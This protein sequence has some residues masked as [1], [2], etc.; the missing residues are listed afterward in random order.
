MRHVTPVFSFLILTL[1]SSVAF[2][3]SEKEVDAALDEAVKTSR[4]EKDAKRAAAAAAENVQTQEAELKALK[5]KRTEQQEKLDQGK[6]ISRLEK[7][8]AE[9]ARKLKIIDKVAQDLINRL[10][11]GIR[12]TATAEENA[13]RAE[14]LGG[15][16][17]PTV[18]N[19]I[20]NSF[21]KKKAELQKA[22]EEKKALLD[23][24]RK[25]AANKQLSE[26]EQAKAQSDIDALDAMIRAKTAEVAAAKIDAA[27]KAAAAKAAAEADAE[28]T[29]KFVKLRDAKAKV[30]AIVQAKQDLKDALEGLRKAG[31]SL[32]AEENRLTRNLDLA[33]TFA[34]LFRAISSVLDLFGNISDVLEFIDIDTKYANP[35]LTKALDQGAKAL[36]AI[37][38][39]LRDKKS[40]INMAIQEQLRSYRDQLRAWINRVR[41]AQRKLE[42]LTGGLDKRQS[43]R[44]RGTNR[45]MAMLKSPGSALTRSTSRQLYA[46]AE[47]SLDRGDSSEL[48]RIEASIA[49]F[50]NAA[51]DGN[52][53]VDLQEATLLASLIDEVQMHHDSLADQISGIDG[54]EV[55]VP[56]FRES[57]VVSSPMFSDS[58]RSIT[59]EAFGDELLRQQ[60]SETVKAG[61]VVLKGNAT[62]S[63]GG[64]TPGL[65]LTMSAPPVG[66]QPAAEQTVN[67]DVDENGQFET[68]IDP[69]W[70]ATQIRFG[71]PNTATSIIEDPIAAGLPGVPPWRNPELSAEV[72]QNVLR[73]FEHFE[74]IVSTTLTGQ[75]QPAGMPDEAAAIRGWRL[76][77]IVEGGSPPLDRMPN[78]ERW[79]KVIQLGTTELFTVEA[80][81]LPTDTTQTSSG[82]PSV[83]VVDE[84]ASRGSGTT[85][86]L[87]ALLGSPANLQ[88]TLP[89]IAERVT[90]VQEV[91]VP[92]DADRWLAILQQAAE[93]TRQTVF[94]HVTEVAGQNH[95]VSVN[96]I[97]QQTTFLPGGSAETADVAL[98]FQLNVKDANGDSVQ[99]DRQQLQT[100]FDNDN[101]IPA[102]GVML[103]REAQAK[104][105]DPFFTSKGTW[106]ETYH[107]QWALRNA[108]FVTPGGEGVWSENPEPCTVAVIGSGVDWTHSELLG[109]MWVNPTEDPYNGI[110]DDG[111]GYVDDQFGWNFR[112]ENSNVLDFGGHDTHIAGVIAARWNRRGIAGANPAARIMA[113]KV[114]NFLGQADSVSISRAVY[115]AVNHGARVINISYNGETASN[116][117]ERAIKYASQRG[118]LVIVSSGN[119]G[120]D[121]ASMALAGSP[122]VL[123][124]A[125][126]DTQNQRAGF[127]NFGQPID[128]SAP[129]M[130]VLGLRAQRT[131]FLLYTGENP[132]YTGGAAIVGEDQ[133]LYRASGTSFAA[134]LVTGAA[135]LIISQHPG[136]DAT[137]VRRMLLMSADDLDAPGWD[138]NTGAGGVNVGRALQQ[139]PDKYLLIR[140]SKLAA[141]R[142]NNQV[143]VQ[144]SGDIE[145]T[146]NFVERTLRIGFGQQP[147]ENSWTTISTSR[148]AWKSGQPLGEVAFSKFNKRGVWS[149][150]IL[151]KDSDGIQRQARAN[152]TVQ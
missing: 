62:T 29:R 113:L 20:R 148:E 17:I 122:N 15:N 110:D 36:D 37:E 13:V 64:E 75:A 53:Q 81:D 70:N 85:V 90:V 95:S 54:N 83:A 114:A 137:Q 149:I 129:A 139:D 108:G 39:I 117:E 50:Q 134:P 130:D 112:D 21:A 73:E 49:E 71:G 57:L 61:A 10:L 31:D 30:A 92:E 123:T 99:I 97:D 109:Q 135:S 101:S 103:P 23:K 33:G 150:Q 111:N 78:L 77:G 32:K 138:Q 133:S 88:N 28:A 94:G 2:G 125:G 91:A 147:A 146:G 82:I 84:E 65:T 24:T 63:T 74:R 27:T 100:R 12:S 6:A 11:A 98:T 80:S 79:S 40:N 3:Q 69:G 152:L 120:A 76:L 96:I 145:A 89:S 132:N 9:I 35:D 93:Q 41:D 56:D 128:I 60:S 86:D 104:P 115:Y 22:L 118:V 116:I 67:V 18:P 68:T 5:K 142:R 34:N 4:A 87:T 45:R 52:D 105:S 26:A 16:S 107:D 44:P 66:N 72:Q 141:S 19:S 7:E 136:L 126:S 58:L 131:D 25:E 48:A 8:I 14:A 59:W 38:A 124:V 121:S 46:A 119:Q 144:I 47:N 43:A 140:I 143:I 1:F 151:A 55:P 51:L 106:G 102:A 42:L 127:S